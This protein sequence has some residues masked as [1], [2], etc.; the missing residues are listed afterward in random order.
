MQPLMTLWFSWCGYRLVFFRSARVGGDHSGLTQR[1]E[2]LARRAATKFQRSELHQAEA[3]KNVCGTAGRN[4]CD[5][6][7]SSAIQPARIGGSGEAI[8]SVGSNGGVI[9]N[10]QGAGGGGE[11]CADVDPR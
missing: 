5:T 2:G 9:K 4:A 10:V 7:G 1:G 6:S 8:K 11:E 3:D